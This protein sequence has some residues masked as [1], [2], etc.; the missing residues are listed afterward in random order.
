NLHWGLQRILQHA[1]EIA[2]FRLVHASATDDRVTTVNGRPN[3]RRGLNYVIEDNREAMV[4]ICF[5]DLTECLGAFSVE[6]ECDFP[7]FLTVS[8]S[9]LRNMVAAEICF[10][11]DQ[12][13]FL[14]RLSAFHLLRISFDSVFW[15]NHFLSFINRF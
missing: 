2:G 6:P 13:T 8:G 10:L 7:S 11:F 15:R 1:R 3:N 14:D 5:S 4:H 12:Q 9:R